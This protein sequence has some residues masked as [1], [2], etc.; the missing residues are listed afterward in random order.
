MLSL[1]ASA[2]LAAE[3]Q[4][5]ADYPTIADAIAASAGSYDD[6]VLVAPGVYTE[7]L[8]VDRLAVVLLTPGAV[9]KPA[10][11]DPVARVRSGGYLVL[12]GGLVEGT[13]GP[14]FDVNGTLGLQSTKVTGFGTSGSTDAAVETSG[15]GS[16]Y[17][18]YSEVYGNV[19]LDGGAV[20]QASFNSM[21]I[22]VSYLHDNVADDRGGA[23]FVGNGSVYSTNS[24]FEGNTALEGGAIWGGGDGVTLSSATVF[25]NTADRGA[26]I[27][28]S[29]SYLYDDRVLFCGNVASTGGATYDLNSGHDSYYGTFVGNVAY[30]GAAAFAGDD[31]TAWLEQALVT[32]NG[33]GAALEGRPSA[34]LAG[35]SPLLWLNALD[36]AG[37]AYVTSPIYAD[38]LYAGYPGVCSISALRTAVGRGAFPGGFTRDADGDGWDVGVDCNDNDPGI[39]PTAV[40][41]VGDDVDANCDGIEICY[42]DRDGDGARDPERFSF[43][44]F[45]AGAQDC[46]Q[47]GYA[48]AS[49]PEDCNDLAPDIH[50]GAVEGIDDGTDQDCDGFELCY[51]D[52]DDDGARAT[53]T[54]DSDDLDCLDAGEGVAADPIDCDDNDA[55]RSPELTEVAGDGIDGDCDDEE[56]CFVDDDGDGFGDGSGLTVGSA[57]LSCVAT[58]VSPHADDCDDGDVDVFPGAVEVAGDGTDQDCDGEELCYLDGDTDGYGSAVTLASSDLDCASAGLSTTMDDCDDSESAAN[59]GATEVPCN[60]FDDDCVGGDDEGDDLDDDGVGACF[61]CDDDDDTVAPGLDEVACDGVDNDCDPSTVDCPDPTTTTEPTTTEPTTT[62]PTDGSP[63]ER[64]S[65]TEPDYGCGCSSGGAAGWAWLAL[66][67]WALRRR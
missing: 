12:Y 28:T 22:D 48:S 23:V 32:H 44:P 20:H 56:I 54:T 37:S 17:L 7:N 15:A 25:G 61:D 60:G 42:L 46:E 18:T 67:P 26:G 66:A 11:P 50:P 59:P 47:A 45:Y 43:A 14:G 38:P 33:P 30:E 55:A 29:G 40:D 27:Y 16:V 4:V 24:R 19:G 13:G 6:Y 9:L 31:S 49:A 35:F 65:P 8:L 63:Q 52:A 41:A 21:N 2:A 53:G 36:V 51:L 3:Y 57:V 34:S 62:G 39:H 58:G 5:P 10:T 1:I 64:P